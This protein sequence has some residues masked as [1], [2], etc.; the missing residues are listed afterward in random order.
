MN[1]IFGVAEQALKVFDKRTEI[2]GNNLANAS[3][4]NFKAQDIDFKSVLQ[5]AS[6]RASYNLSTTQKG[7]MSSGN[8]FS[9]ATKYRVPNQPALDG[10]TV[11]A[12]AERVK[13]MENSM[14][15]QTSLTFIGS[16]AEKLKK[17]FRGE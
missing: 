8:E 17:A 12:D 5:E 7:H 13:F 11:D 4:P 3:T 10:N 1:S 15:Y 2:L 6:N 9:Y 14:Q 16:T